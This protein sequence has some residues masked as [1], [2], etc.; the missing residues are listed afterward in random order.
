[1]GD[2]IKLLPDTIANQIAAGE[3]IQ[4][5]ASVIKELV[6]N[7]VDADAT[8]ITVDIKDS[9]KTLI[10]VTDNGK[11]MN[12]TDAR[13]SFE[14]HA[15]SKISSAADLFA[16]NT[17]GFRGEALASISAIAHVTLKTKSDETELGTLIEINGGRVEI[18]EPV[19]CLQGSQIAV[20]NLF[21]NVPAR[22]KFLKSDNV[23]MR[24][25]IDQFE[26]VALAHP[27]IKFTLT[28]NTNE[29]FILPEGNMRQRLIG[30][31]GRKYNEKLVPVEQD[32]QLVNITGFVLKPEAAKKTRGEQF[33]FVNNRFIK[34]PYLHQ[35]VVQA[36]D[37]LLPKGFHPGYFIF[38]EVEPSFIDIN[39][40]P[41]KTEIKFED[42]RSVGMLM[43]S[44]VK[45]SI[46]MFNVSPT[47]DFNPETSF[48]PTAIPKGKIIMEPKISVNQN[49][50]P[51]HLSND[52][53]KK[54]SSG[55]IQNLQ[56]MY[57]DLETISHSSDFGGASQIEASLPDNGHKAHSISAFQVKNK[58][59]FTTIKS[60]IIIINQ[61]RAH[62][63]V[64]FDRLMDQ[65][66]NEQGSSQQLLF[67]ENVTFSPN[68]TTLLNELMP[69]LK[70]LGFD[71]EPFGANTFIVR[72][73]PSMS[74]SQDPKQLI[75]GTLYGYESH[76]ENPETAQNEALIGALA[77]KSAIKTGQ[78]L[79]PEEIIELIDELFASPN[80]ISLP[81]GRKILH[82]LDVDDVEKFFN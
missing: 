43:R 24:H 69:T 67:P 40:H 8:I 44:A 14:R 70:L 1:M 46:G 2:I 57:E 60:G 68:Q 19:A 35:M 20:K 55:E 52:F 5:P 63:R 50:N 9:G 59:I 48:A 29:V 21:Y 36:Y 4:R 15:T 51:F 34:S 58:F 79:R 26:R 33:F 23:E 61:T 10:M 75:E 39:I 56:S 25:I 74:A 72:G 17:K 16:L 41:T 53:N 81:D 13:M 71:I 28:H 22:R 12:E 47:I 11:G 18:Q 37:E 7:A 54:P 6:E 82:Q 78:S 32:T 65:L 3:V 64:L 76:M 45:Q 38:L 49:F 77:F 66:E 62:Q 80:P 31:F 30:V 73:L 42:E 27:K